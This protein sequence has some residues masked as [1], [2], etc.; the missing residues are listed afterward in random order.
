[1]ENENSEIDERGEIAQPILGRAIDELM[2]RGFDY[3]DA[4]HAL[5]KMGIDSLPGG[6]CRECLRDH[7]DAVLEAVEERI[8][9]IPDLVPGKDC[10]AGP[11]DVH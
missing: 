3:L 2:A 10:A 5:V 9:E 8:A 4:C 6:A 7:Y 1:M 11:C